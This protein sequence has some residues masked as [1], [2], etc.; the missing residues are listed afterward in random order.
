MNDENKRTKITLTYIMLFS[1]LV[2]SQDISWQLIL[3]IPNVD[4]FIFLNSA[5]IYQVGASVV[6]IFLSITTTDDNSVLHKVL[7][8]RPQISAFI[9]NY[10][11]ISIRIFSWI[12][13]LFLYIPMIFDTSK[14]YIPRLA[15]EMKQD[16]DTMTDKFH[17]PI[18][19]VRLLSGALTTI[20]LV[21]LISLFLPVHIVSLIADILNLV[22]NVI[23][24]LFVANN[25]KMKVLKD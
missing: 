12:I 20:F 16:I 22:V 4:N 14:R 25:A 10:L 15:D 11:Y 23:G 17:S 1:S 3:K 5:S 21:Y 6:Y 8:C 19:E 13:T 9:D 24:C 7:E 2:L 18:F